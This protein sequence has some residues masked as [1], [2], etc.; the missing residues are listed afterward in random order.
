MKTI[1]GIETILSL[2]IVLTAGP[3]AL[4]APP[5]A[6][7]TP[8]GG[9]LPPPR[10]RSG[11]SVEEALTQ[12]RS[13]RRFASRALTLE[14]LSQLL[15]A[16]QGVTDATNG[17]RTA[18]SAGATYPLVLYAVTSRGVDR[19]L[20]DGHRLERCLAG[21]LRSVIADAALGQTA[22]RRAPLTI[23]IAAVR[24]RTTRRYGDRGE[25]YIH[26]EAGHAAQNLLLQ[27]VALE[28]AAVPVGAFEPAGLARAL[29]LPANEQPL[30]LVPVG[31]VQG[32]EQSDETHS[33]PR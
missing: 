12:R 17:R 3:S 18:P 14:E 8:S 26:M 9:L 1:R 31:A 29:N 28:L 15:W 30:Y 10:L 24:P 23:V 6:G 13:V 22:V 25:M 19:Y 33:T 21:D 5:Q 7:A 16:A 32:S 11:T 27:A 20:P 4:G 2:C